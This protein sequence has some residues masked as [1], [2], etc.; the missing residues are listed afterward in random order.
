M[1]LRCSEVHVLPCTPPP[2][3]AVASRLQTLMSGSALKEPHL[4]APLG[5]ETRTP[6]AWDSMIGLIITLNGHYRQ[7]TCDRYSLNTSQVP[8]KQTIVLSLHHHCKSTE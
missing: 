2:V 3:L 4:V 5:L 8:F 1:A 6:L 7:N